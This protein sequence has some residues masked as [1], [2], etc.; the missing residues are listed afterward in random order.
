MLE[1]A[2]LSYFYPKLCDSANELFTLGEKIF[3]TTLIRK[4][5]RS[6]PNKFNSKVIAI[7]EARDLDSMKVE[8]LIRS[9]LT[10]N[11]KKFLKKV[12]KSSKSSP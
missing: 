1:D 4:I 12:G 6:F 5:M 3:E 8:N 11:F 10:K 7:E 9:L 2:S